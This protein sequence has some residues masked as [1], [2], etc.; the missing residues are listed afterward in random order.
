MN[1]KSQFHQPA[2]QEA[3]RGGGWGGRGE[4]GRRERRRDRERG[5]L[6]GKEETT[7]LSSYCL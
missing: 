2:I 6:K 5:Q 7:G 1:P 4:E 3:H